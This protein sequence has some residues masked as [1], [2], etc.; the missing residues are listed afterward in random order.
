MVAWVPRVLRFEHEVKPAVGLQYFHEDLLGAGDRLRAQGSIWDDLGRRAELSYEAP[1]LDGGGHL[2][3]AVVYLAHRDWSFHGIGPF[4][5]QHDERYFGQ[6][7]VDGRLELGLDFLGLSRLTLSASGRHVELGR[8]ADEPVHTRPELY[9]P[10]GFPDA[11]TL[12]GLGV[13]LELDSR[14]TEPAHT[15]GSGL[16]LA[17][18]A[19]L[20]LDP[21][22]PSLAFLRWSA[23][24]AAF[25]DFT[26]HNHV[27]A[28]RA[29]AGFVGGLG[30]AVV[31]VPELVQLG[32]MEL[33]E[34][35]RRGRFHGSSALVISTAYRYPVW[36]MLDAHL[37]VSLGNTFGEHLEGFR[38]DRL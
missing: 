24:G 21:T 3:A 18:D 26:G 17:A 12:L 16:L 5:L 35:F 13:R 25:W 29:F 6:E 36:A 8:G 31:P 27:L 28:L 11:Y 22:D 9:A 7:R 1:L 15:P 23:E 20:A 38:P 14:A 32:G 33:M 37:Q 2:G 19:H 30:A 4:A 10:A 34:G